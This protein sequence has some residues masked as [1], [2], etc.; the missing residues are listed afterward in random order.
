MT[1]R[2]LGQCIIYDLLIQL[3]YSEKYLY[4][5]GGWIMSNTKIESDGNPT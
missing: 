2:R 5:E 3:L 1:E 4:I